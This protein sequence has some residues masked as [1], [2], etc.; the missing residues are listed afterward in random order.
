MV[1]SLKMDICLL[2]EWKLIAEAIRLMGSLDI[3]PIII[4]QS[5]QFPGPMNW[6]KAVLCCALACVII[7]RRPN[8]NDS[9]AYLGFSY[10]PLLGSV[11]INSYSIS[12]AH[13][14][15]VLEETPSHLI[16]SFSSERWKLKVV[17]APEPLHSPN[18]SHRKDTRKALGFSPRDLWASKSE[19]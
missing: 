18:T 4:F 6:E 3:H 2:K 10:P 7:Q 19:S 12:E 14:I 17:I 1:L 16:Q 13:R 15:C 5:G 11:F 8:N 9:S